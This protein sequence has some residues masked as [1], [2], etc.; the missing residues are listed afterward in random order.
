MPSS[1]KRRRDTCRL[2]SSSP[3]NCVIDNNA[4]NR[5]VAIQLYRIKTEKRSPRGKMNYITW[6][7]TKEWKRFLWRI[8]FFLLSILLEGSLVCILTEPL[9]NIEHFSLFICVK[10]V[11]THIIIWFPLVWQPIPNVYSSSHLSIV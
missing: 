6:M 5:S 4:H 9:P 7:T 11:P 1:L 3:N 2:K 10:R 8:F